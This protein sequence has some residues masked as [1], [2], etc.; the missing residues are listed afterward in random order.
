M[1]ALAAQV[2]LA[3][4]LI[5]FAATG[6]P[7]LTRGANEA[8]ADQPAPAASVNRFDV[9]R[10]WRDL[11]LQVEA[12][13]RPAGSPALRRLASV[14]RARLPGGRFE[15]VPGGLR[16]VVGVLPGRRPAIVIGAHYDTEA[17][18]R[19]FVGANDGAAGTAAVIE[20]ARA[21]RRHR[22]PG[23]RELRFVLFDGE[24]EPAGSTDFARD[25]LRGSTAYVRRH[26]RA[27]GE[28]ILLDYVANRGLA[29]EREQGSDRRLWAQL[30]AAAGRVG[31]ARVFPNRE[32]AEEI[33]DD[34]TPFTRAGIPA[35]DLIDFDYPHR[36]TVR[37]TVDK[38]DP[39]S[40]D[41]VG[42]AVV[43]L[44]RTR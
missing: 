6:F 18:P 25:G 7:F 8:R 42:E 2:V 35:I 13:Q 26:R 5:Y 1:I 21:L 22:A 41:A 11:R 36:D 12:G 9:R 24:E 30:R 28:M 14:L 38:L 32:R 10:A 17:L 16:N 33:L 31:V 37:D 27:V 40:L 43:E 19:G 3:G 20:L 29:I 4:V 23:G 34:H 15:P 44:V 39:R